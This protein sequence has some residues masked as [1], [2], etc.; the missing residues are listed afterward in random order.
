MKIAILGTRGIP[1]T[2]G[3]FEQFAEFFSVFLKEKGHDVYVY[4]SSSHEYQDKE[5]KGVKL[6]HCKDPE[7]KIGTVGQFIYDFNCIHDA[8]KRN[9]DIILQLGYTSSS[10]WRRYLPR[11]SMI[12]TN[13]DGLEWK[14]TKFSKKVRRF[15]KYAE[16][17]AVKGSDHLIAD[18]LGIQDYLKQKYDVESRYI[19]Y[20]ATVFSNPDASVIN[21]YGLK[22]FKY[23]M[24]IARMEPENSIEIILDGVVSSGSEE[25]FLVVGKHDVN[26]F[27]VYLKEKF[28]ANE[29]IKFLGGIYNQDH[30]NNLR[31][32][33]KL[34][35]HGHTVGG[36]NPSL[37]E[38]M[39]SNSLIAAHNNKFNAAILGEDAFYFSSADEVAS[40]L[41]KVLSKNDYQDALIH[42]A[43]KIKTMYSWELINKT[44]LDFFEEKYATYK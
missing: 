39:G 22:P 1:N 11:K 25:T 15:L 7:H 33:S 9:F 42:N 26:K 10:I 40:V 29:N 27:G 23:N 41:K 43:E 18:S 44:Y 31:H 38:A 12:V 16:S 20:G 19:P 14:R 6:V 2:Y 3:G 32:Y 36:T 37:L 30:L 24:L 34:Y 28:R 4:S 21:N 35:F 17:L 13:M 8:R 5:Y